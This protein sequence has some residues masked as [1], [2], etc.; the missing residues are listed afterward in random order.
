MSFLK[1][2]ANLGVTIAASFVLI[3]LGIVYFMITIWI[4]KIGASWAGFS[5]VQGSTVVLTTGIITA[6]AL[7]GS[8][9]Q[10]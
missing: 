9:I 1:G 5:N 3:F 6:A 10:K 8:A 7:I 4:I 2:L